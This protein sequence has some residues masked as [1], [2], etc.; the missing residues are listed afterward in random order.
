MNLSE[1]VNDD[2]T[3]NYEQFKKDIFV[4]VKALNDVLD[5]GL[6][7]HPLEEQRNSVRDWRQIGLGVMGIADM[8]IKMKIRYGSKESQVVC[9]QIGYTLAREALRSSSM[10]SAQDG[11][12]NG[13]DE[14][15]IDTSFF[16]A[17]T[18]PELESDVK[19][20]GLRNSQLLTIAPTGTIS[21]MIGVSGG[22]EPIFSTHYTR[23]TKSLHGKDVTYKVYTPIVK[24]FMEKNGIESEEDLP[25]FFVTSGNIPYK[26]RIDMQAVWQRH[27]DASISSTVNLPKETTIEEVEDL[28]MYAWEQGLKGITIYRA[29]CA[30]E[31]ILVTE[32]TKKEETNNVPYNTITPISRKTF[33]TTHGN[34]YCKKCACGTLY[35]TLNRDDNGNLVESFINT[36]KGGICQANIGAINRMISVSLRSGVKV[37]EI[38]DQLKG[39][40]CPACT[41]LISKGEQLSGI[42]CP[43]ILAKTLLEEYLGKT[44]NEK[45]EIKKNNNKTIDFITCPDCGE[46]LIHDGGCVTC[47][48]CGWSKCS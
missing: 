40:T 11:T 18:T 13:F 38:I 43:D 36:S 16:R 28:Y 42:S 22:I 5:E 12:Y 14:G 25:D 44:S 21:T 46:S 39:I 27:I 6:E 41:K 48:N 10:L 37:E 47:T 45:K 1:Y 29:G 32:E 17:H 7:R 35:V 24:D 23:T 20:F 15:V 3:F 4:V 34:T 9:E 33:G 26:E 19:E 30:R 2:C 31:G 8:L